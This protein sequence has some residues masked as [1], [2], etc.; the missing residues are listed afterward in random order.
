MEGLG[1]GEYSMSSRNARLNPSVH[2]DATQMSEMRKITYSRLEF[3]VMSRQF[4]FYTYLMISIFLRY[5]RQQEHFNVLQTFNRMS[6]Y[7]LRS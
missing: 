6:S 3:L 7:H 1:A 5:T 4:F 2:T